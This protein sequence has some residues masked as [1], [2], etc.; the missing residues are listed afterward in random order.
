MQAILLL[1][2]NGKQWQEISEEL[3]VPL[4]TASSFYQR[5]MRKIITYLKKYI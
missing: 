1:V 4:S 5:R 3:K 2:L